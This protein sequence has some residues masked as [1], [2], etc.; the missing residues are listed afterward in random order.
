VALLRNILR[1]R[2]ILRIAL[3][4]INIAFENKLKNKAKCL[5]FI[6]EAKEKEVDLI[7]FPE[8][9]L[10]GFSMNV[11]LIGEN[12]NET[13]EWLK[14]QAVSFGIYI[15]LG[16]V[17]KANGKGLN[18]FTMVS[19]DGKEI[20]SYSKIHPFSYSNENKFYEGG[21]EITFSEIKDF[22]ISSF[23]CYD[24]RFPE[25]FQIASRKAHLIIVAANWPK[26]RREHWIT[27]LRARAIENQCYISGVN[28]LGVIDGLEYSGDSMII[29]PMGNI[30][31]VASCKEELVI[32][33]INI[34][35]VLDY[36]NNFPV[37]SD[38]KENLYA[39]LKDKL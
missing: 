25:I 26:S 17:A 6:K 2:F 37:K 15:G 35:E 1:R 39:F 23:I 20:C 5:Q 14:E 8:M 27:L 10:T 31:A 24:L 19:P 34:S 3:A 28:A 33:D 9:S 30:I 7:I 13:I 22:I 29:D 16:H 18:K 11:E 12:D 4:Q 36:R 21:T 32:G 38:R